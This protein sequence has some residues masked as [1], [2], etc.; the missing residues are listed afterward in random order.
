MVRLQVVDLLAEDERP[1][2][3][4][5]EL[6][7]VERVGEAGP[8]AREAV[9][10]EPRNRQPD[11]PSP[12]CSSSSQLLR[13]CKLVDEPV[14]A[15]LMGGQQDMHPSTA[16][17]LRKRG[18]FCPSRRN[19]N[20][21]RKGGGIDEPLHDPQA[22]AIP[23]ALQPPPDHLPPPLLPFLFPIRT[24]P[25]LSIHTPLALAPTVSLHTPLRVLSCPSGPVLP[26]KKE[27]TLVRRR[28]RQIV[29]DAEGHGHHLDHEELEAGGVEEGGGRV[30]G[31]VGGEGGLEGHLCKGR[32][33]G[34]GWRYGGW[35][36]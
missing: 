3:L 10:H 11:V 19:E 6:D 24:P 16:F 7:H 22:H 29:C 14:C 21:E 25:A 26:V 2:V 8:V 18:L 33:G 35:G 5:Q 28:A 32:G 36:G 9:P 15:P 20:G 31:G 1:D 13:Y 34:G 17:S 27:R 12:A 23:H 4:A 30:G